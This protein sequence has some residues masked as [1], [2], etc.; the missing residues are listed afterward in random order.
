[1]KLNLIQMDKE[2]LLAE[3]LLSDVRS[4]ADSSDFE[5]LCSD[6]DFDSDVFS[7]I[8]VVQKNQ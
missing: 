6:F 8:F 1:M 7:F 3:L 5:K 4:D 2:N